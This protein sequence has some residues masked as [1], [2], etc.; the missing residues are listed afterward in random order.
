M[1]EEQTSGESVADH[2]MAVTPNSDPSQPREASP[3]GDV[4][5]STT[6]VFL[7][8]VLHYCGPNNQLRPVLQYTR[9][10]ADLRKDIL[11]FFEIISYLLMAARF[12]INRP[13]WSIFSQL[14][15]FL[16]SHQIVS[17]ASSEHVVERFFFWLLARIQLQEQ[18]ALLKLQQDLPPCMQ[19]LPSHHP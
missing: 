5:F 13:L 7:V 6:L 15:P 2:D 8:W 18:E 3:S 1:L 4:G 11:N 9:L 17:E 14:E 10:W 16:Y 12:P 19:S